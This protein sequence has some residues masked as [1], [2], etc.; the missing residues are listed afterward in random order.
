[1]AARVGEEQSRAIPQGAALRA[2]QCDRAAA[3]L[4][5][6]GSPAGQCDDLALSFGRDCADLDV[7]HAGHGGDGEDAAVVGGGNRS[8]ERKDDAPDRQTVGVRIASR[9]S[10]RGDGSGGQIDRAQHVVLLV[11][12][13]K[14]PSRAE[15]EAHR[16][17]EARLRSDSVLEAVGAARAG[18]G[19][20]GVIRIGSDLADALVQR[21]GDVDVSR[22]IRPHGRGIREVRAC[23]RKRLLV[24]VA[25]ARPGVRGALADAADLVLPRVGVHE[26]AVR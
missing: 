9:I 25:D 8:H 18:E 14:P 20:H 16:I 10:E 5:T 2:D 3:V 7:L 4:E 12:D 15:R 24:R 23:C 26:S 6:V 1:M 17:A 21:I 13:E 22:G 19:G 11:R